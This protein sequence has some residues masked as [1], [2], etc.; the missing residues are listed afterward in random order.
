MHIDE[1]N[2]NNLTGLWKKYGFDVLKDEIGPAMFINPRWP[3][4]CWYD[5]N[6]LTDDL[7]NNSSQ[8]INYGAVLTG[9]PPSAVIPVWPLVSC[10]KTDLLPL[11]AEHDFLEKELIA[12]KWSCHFEQ[13]AMFLELQDKMAIVPSVNTEFRMRIVRSY[14]ELTLWVDICEDAFGYDIEPLVLEPL[15]GDKDIQIILGDIKGQPVAAA[16]LYKT[17]NT[18]GIH[19]VGVRKEFQGKGIASFLM[20]DILVLCVQW[21]GKNAVLQASQAGFPLYHR[22]GF[23]R[24]FV[25]KNYQRAT[26]RT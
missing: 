6:P 1:E 7:T 14:E 16:L 4:R 10:R 5:C 19:Q 17:G 21:G 24:Q 26:Q 12:H 15:I 18:I 2:L 9:I 3:R 20:N 11:Q 8:P 25:I 23:N 22:L 13:T